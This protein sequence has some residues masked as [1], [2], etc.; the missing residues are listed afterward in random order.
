ML[1]HERTI[2]GGRPLSRLPMPPL[3]PWIT[4]VDQPSS[5]A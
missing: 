3:P 4:L 1:Q 2:L 5:T